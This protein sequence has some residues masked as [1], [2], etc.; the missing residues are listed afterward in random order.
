MKAKDFRLFEANREETVNS[1]RDLD[2]IAGYLKDADGK[3]IRNKDNSPVKRG[4]FNLYHGKKEDE[5][6]L[7]RSVVDIAQ[8]GQAIYEFLQNAV[9]AQANEF[10]IFYNKNFFL[11][12]N[13]GK[14]FKPEEISSI[15]NL[16][17][18][19]KNDK[20]KSI[21]QFGIGFKLIHRLIG[22]DNGTDE[23]KEY[24]GPLLLSWDNGFLKEFVKNNIDKIEDHWY[25]KILYTCF[26]CGI[27]EKVK[28]VNYEDI[29]PFKESEHNKLIVYLNEILK[30]YNI[31]L[32]KKLSEGSLFFLEFGKNKYQKLKDEE[33]KIK[34]GIAYSLNILEKNA[35]DT[36][37]GIK[38]I[39]INNLVIEKPS[40]RHFGD[41]SYM[42]MYHQTIKDA[43]EY[44]RKPKNE[45]V[46]FFKYFPMESQLNNLN[47]ILHSKEFDIETN[48]QELQSNTNIDLL[49]NIAYKIILELEIIKLRNPNDYRDILVNLYLSDLEEADG[50]R[51]I[52]ENFTSQLREYIKNNIPTND[53]VF[54]EDASRVKIVNSELDIKL[55]AHKIFFHFKKNSTILREAQKKL[56]IEEWNIIDALINDDIEIWVKSLSPNNDYLKFLTEIDKYVNVKNVELI[57]NNNIFLCSDGLYKS[58]CEIEKSPNCL[59]RGF[60]DFKIEE[61]L[62]KNHA[63]KFTVFNILNFKKLSIFL[64]K[65]VPSASIFSGQ[66]KLDEI[67]DILNLIESLNIK[68]FSVCQRSNFYIIDPY[69]ENIFIK[70]KSLRTFFENNEDLKE[71]SNRNLIPEPVQEQ[72][73]RLLSLH[74]SDEGVKNL[75]IQNREPAEIIDLFVDEKTEF[76]VELLKKIFNVLFDSD[77]KYERCSYE[78]K[79]LDLILSI[80][81]ESNQDYR[82]KIT[83]NEKNITNSFLHDTISFKYGSIPLKE[84]NYREY[85]DNKYINIDGILEEFDTDKASKLKSTL[86]KLEE[87]N[88][89]FLYNNICK[90]FICKSLEINKEAQLKFIVFFSLEKH[91]NYLKDFKKGFMLWDWKNQKTDLNYSFKIVADLLNII[92]AYQDSTSLFNIKDF[93][94]QYFTSSYY[95]TGDDALDV[96]KLPNEFFASDYFS[97]CINIYSHFGLVLNQ[98]LCLIRRKIL[99]N[100]KVNRS[101]LACLSLEQLNYT[102]EYLALMN[103]EFQTD[104][105]ITSTSTVKEIYLLIDDLSKVTYFPILQNTS[106][107]K[108]MKVN[109]SHELYFLTKDELH[110]VNHYFQSRLRADI[111]KNNVLFLF[112]SVVPLENW[113][114]VKPTKEEN[115]KKLLDDGNMAIKL[116]QNTTEFSQSDWYIGHKGEQHVYELLLDKY[117]DTGDVIWNNEN[118]TNSDE[119]SGGIDIELHINGKIHQIEVKTTVESHRNNSVRF[120]M[121]S[122]Q[123]EAATSWGKNTHLVFVTDINASPKVLYFN[124]N[125]NW[126]DDFS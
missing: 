78:Y 63:V 41:D 75:L 113:T 18:S 49:K 25:F 4:F 94:P 56:K 33:Q 42:F 86:F 119:D 117:G 7:I 66:Y 99:R 96:E 70:D 103:N 91:S 72:V 95:L 40:M 58:I 34:N 93:F 54:Y 107:F 32:S 60:L 92:L 59:Y 51:I 114:R 55:N 52:K 76:K 47:F 48:R 5:I 13:N 45:K 74:P 69:H 12:I 27:N 116:N 71:L 110:K 109:P 15:L 80:G 115:K 106:F 122:N 9:D 21:G 19:T 26:P 125:E 112:D 102:L 16:G 105:S 17:Q 3:P 85:K 73:V 39:R 46:S 62:E 37:S 38:K 97:E 30:L 22:V 98:S 44:Y 124:F 23:I 89:E 83:I 31:D 77:K 82:R 88:K 28:G 10:L 20:S 64:Q 108:L 8:D 120:F 79:V 84:I 57:S 14:K 111:S 1:S 126:L 90:Y 87:E 61:I 11:S 29:T 101:E 53:G 43:L 68:R 121:S 100:L 81:A 35:T 67:R 36:F 118:V 24:K 50:D 65:P 6:A 123:F 104:I 2:F